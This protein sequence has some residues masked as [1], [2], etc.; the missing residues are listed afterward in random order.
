MRARYRKNR[1]GERSASPPTR[2]KSKQS[3]SN[4]HLMRKSHQDGSQQSERE[5]SVPAINVANTW[6]PR[7]ARYRSTG[8]VIHLE[9][10]PE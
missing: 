6:F 9:N 2:R 10:F 4:K 8:R 3:S 1:H 7:A 5:S